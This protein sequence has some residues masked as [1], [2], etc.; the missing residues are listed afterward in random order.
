MPCIRKAKNIAALWAMLTAEE[1]DVSQEKELHNIQHEV[2]KE[3][4]GQNAD[5]HQILDTISDVKYAELWVEVVARYRARRKR[6]LSA[7]N[8]YRNQGNTDKAN[9]IES[10]V[11]KEDQVIELYA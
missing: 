6:K 4:Y 10:E 11:A 2:I 8:M 3:R 9:A 5:V 7:A 1:K